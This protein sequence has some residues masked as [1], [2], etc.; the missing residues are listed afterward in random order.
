MIKSVKTHEKHPLNNISI[1][2]KYSSLFNERIY[3]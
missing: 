3:T 2:D 1:S